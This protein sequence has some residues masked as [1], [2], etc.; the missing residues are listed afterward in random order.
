M[1]DLCKKCLELNYIGSFFCDNAKPNT[2]L[3]GYID[4]Y[5][6]DEIIIKHIS[7][8]GYYDGFILV[9][10]SDI[11]R[12]DVLGKY[13]NRI[14]SLFSIRKQ[15]HPCINY[16][17]SSL[18]LSLIDFACANNLV[19]SVELE[20]TT[21]SG[22]VLNFNEQEIHIQVV[23]ENG[24]TDGETIVLVDNVL[25]FAVDT[26]A[27]QNLKLLARQNKTRGRKTDKTGDGSL[28]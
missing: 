13:E 5:N 17:N 10:T 20:N 21:I 12:V 8:D 11:I 6:E 23:D 27:E 28:S 25:S 16:E 7:P 19:V 4:G 2:H 15:T 14:A 26:I 18:Y 22:F 9:H 24:L 1:I 3:T